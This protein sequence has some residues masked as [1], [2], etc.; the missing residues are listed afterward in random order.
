MQRKIIQN[1]Y[2]VTYGESVIICDNGATN[3][4][5]TLPPASE[6]VY[7]EFYISRAPGSTGTIT[8]KAADNG[9]I[10]SL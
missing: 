7:A 4:T 6:Y 1:T 8:V 3:I 10:Q 5:V 2:T 9:P